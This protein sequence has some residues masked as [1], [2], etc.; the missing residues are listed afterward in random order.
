MEEIKKLQEHLHD[1]H[2]SARCT[3]LRLD[4][5]IEDLNNTL[6]TVKCD[7]EDAYKRRN[8]K[9]KEL[10]DARAELNILRTTLGITESVLLNQTPKYGSVLVVSGATRRR[11]SPINDEI[12]ELERKLEEV[13]EE[14]DMLNTGENRQAIGLGFSKTA[15]EE[16]KRLHQFIDDLI[17]RNKQSL[18]ELAE[19]RANEA[20]IIKECDELEGSLDPKMPETTFTHCVNCGDQLKSGSY[21]I[22]EHCFRE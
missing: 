14:R 4:A 22:C 5:H 1:A 17:I 12:I 9:E 10:A 18:D 15:D 19:Y 3:A 11:I 21:M 2:E 8:V 16:I 13:T 6:H 7:L 20:A